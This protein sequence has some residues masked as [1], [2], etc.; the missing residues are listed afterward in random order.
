MKI[1]LKKHL[2]YFLLI[3]IG[4]FV[5]A[6][7]SSPKEEPKPETSTECL[8]KNQLEK[9][10]PILIEPAKVSEKL[11]LNGKVDYNPNALVSYVPLVSGTISHTYVSLGDKVQKGQTLAEI[12][13]IELNEMKTKLN[14]LENELEVAKRELQSVQGFYD[15]DIASERELLEAQSEKENMESELENLRTNLQM[16]CSV[17]GKNLFEI[18]A[19]QSGYLVENKLASGMQIRAEGDPIFTISDMDEVWVNM[20]IYATHLNLVKEGMSISIK[21]KAYPDQI[22][23]G[24][25]TRISHVMDPDENVLKARV[26]LNNKDLMLKPGLQVEGNVQLEN[27]LKMPRLP[28]QAVVYHNDKYYVVLIQDEC[29]LVQREVEIYSQDEHTMYIKKGLET[30]EKIIGKNALLEFQQQLTNQ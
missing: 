17:K 12:R 20:N 6:C 7:N 22:F 16:Y 27:E 5:F 24:E 18:R 8:S 25:I 11:R 9:L 1:K 23:E 10:Q 21:V 14:Q 3:G 19:P 13:S 4:L 2:Y 15:D 29:Q 30:G 28:D 26:V